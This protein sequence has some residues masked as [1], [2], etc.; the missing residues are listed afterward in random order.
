MTIRR[1]ASW[2]MALCMIAVPVAGQELTDEERARILEVEQRAVDI[3]TP[4]FMTRDSVVQARNDVTTGPQYVTGLKLMPRREGNAPRIA[5]VTRYQ[6]AG[7]IT[8]HTYVDVDAERAVS[9]TPYPNFPTPLSAEELDRAITLASEQVPELASA[10]NEIGRENLLVKP[11]TLIVS[12]A[13]AP[14]YGHR[15]AILHFRTRQAMDRQISSVHVDLTD[16]KAY[17]L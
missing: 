16:G 4:G 11:M 7:G 9:V 10:V 5:E 6:Y 8:V 17:A 14:N 3:A 12:T 1:M 13:G 2:V 15:I